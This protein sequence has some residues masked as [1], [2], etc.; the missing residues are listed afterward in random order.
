M[1]IRLSGFVLSPKPLLELALFLG[2]QVEEEGLSGNPPPL[3]H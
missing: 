2:V 3:D 1:D